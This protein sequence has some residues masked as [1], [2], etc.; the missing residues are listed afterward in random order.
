[1]GALSPDTLD[2]WVFTPSFALYPPYTRNIANNPQENPQNDD[3]A[4]TNK[5]QLMKFPTLLLI[6]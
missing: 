5:T 1:M 6:S 4:H 3:G 2:K